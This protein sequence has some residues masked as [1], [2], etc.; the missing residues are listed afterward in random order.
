M[1]GM[2]IGIAC[3][4]ALVS[5]ALAQEQ[6]AAPASPTIRFDMMP[7]GRD[8]ARNYPSAARREGAPGVVAL[9]CT[10]QPDRR[11]ACDVAAEWPQERGFGA[12]SLMVM[13]EFRVFEESYLQ[14]QAAG[15]LSVPRTLL[16]PLPG[17]SEPQMQ[18]L[19][20]VSARL[21]QGVSCPVT[22]PVPIAAP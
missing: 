22:A 2:M 14:A 8:F 16:W 10:I 6:A 11:L 21:R 19:R 5:G 9:C 12:A 7:D 17:M 15:D 1:R 3:V 13:R 4:I 18:Q 20:E